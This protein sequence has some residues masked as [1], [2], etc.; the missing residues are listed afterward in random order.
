MQVSSTEKEQVNVFSRVIIKK[1][2][3]PLSCPMPNMSL[4]D[5]H[6]KVFLAL[7]ENNSSVFPYCGTEYH[8]TED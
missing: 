3:L 7:D 4:W 5:M 8:V 6:P 2:D 1:E